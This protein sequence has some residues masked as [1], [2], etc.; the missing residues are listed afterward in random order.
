MRNS[1]I[2][3]VLCV[4][5]AVAGACAVQAPASRTEVRAP[6]TRAE[7]DGG[8]LIK[9]SAVQAQHALPEDDGAPVVREAPAAKPGEQ[10]PRRAGPAML[11]AVLAVMSGI[12]LRGY[13][14]RMK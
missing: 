5:S 7:Q 1:V 14:S 4:S 3:I 13:G 2:A 10:Q 12:A 9:T 8:V 6:A 11:L